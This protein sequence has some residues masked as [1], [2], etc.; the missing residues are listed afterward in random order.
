MPP[1]TKAA[2]LGWPAGKHAYRAGRVT[3]RNLLPRG[4]GHA[5]ADNS[6]KR[7]ALGPWKAHRGAVARKS[8]LLCLLPDHDRPSLLT[9]G[10]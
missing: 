10:P 3:C 7:V 2:L 6:K 1:A 4:R 8:R 9:S 5:T